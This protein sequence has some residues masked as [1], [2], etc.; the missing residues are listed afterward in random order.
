MAAESSNARLQLA[1]RPF[2]RRLRRR[3]AA[4]YLP[5]AG[6]IALVAAT[7]ATWFSMN[8]FTA[9]LFAAVFAVAAACALAFIRTP[10]IAATARIVDAELQLQDRT[11]SA[12]QFSALDDA[13][14]R[15]V[16][17]EGISRLQSQK[18]ASLRVTVPA[19]GRWL[20]LAAALLFV[21]VFVAR[22]GSSSAPASPSQSGAAVTTSRGASQRG[23]TPT[24]AAASAPAGAAR[25]TPSLSGA[26]STTPETRRPE[27]QR[28][29]ERAGATERRDS[30]AHADN[31]TGSPAAT[32]A[33][34]D[35]MRPAPAGAGAA[36][37]AGQGGAATALAS[38]PSGPG[39]GAGAAGGRE[40]AAGG[41]A[42][43]KLA[44]T[45]PQ[46]TPGASAARGDRRDA[47]YAAAYARAESA[48]AAEHVPVR[49]RSYVRAYFLAIR[50]GSQ[51]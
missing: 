42:G 46:P 7:I 26:G 37:N 41:V 30:S 39:R 43:A 3:A 5:V 27:T 25:E 35:A 23:G 24:A 19:R 28:N 31:A 10:T 16:V 13:I 11:V 47:A 50:P 8:A 33:T 49:L 38:N 15:L 9:L 12:L 2:Q 45:N 6:A 18:S 4:R 21:V 20:C 32:A 40:R 17:N 36:Q 44:G 34:T 14:A 51:P 22:D 48:T 29:A 1:L